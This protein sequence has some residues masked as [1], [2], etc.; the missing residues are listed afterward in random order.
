[1]GW[2]HEPLVG[3]EHS[4]LKKKNSAKLGTFLTA[5]DKKKLKFYFTVTPRP[6]LF[7]LNFPEALG[8]FM[9]I[10]KF[11][12]WKYAQKLVTCND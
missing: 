12:G 1:V 4:V 11:L 8:T 6:Q 10:F 7:F 9:P 2:K 5:A 3:P